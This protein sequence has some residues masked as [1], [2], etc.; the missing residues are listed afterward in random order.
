MVEV[1]LHADKTAIRIEYFGDEIERSPRSTQLRGTV[2]RELD[3]YAIYP[4]SHYVT[5]EE[6]RAKAIHS[7]RAELRER[8]EELQDAGKL[9]ERQRLEQR[10]SFDLEMLEQIGHCQGIENYSRHLS[11]RKA[12][13]PPPTLIDYLPEDFLM[14]L[15]ESHQTIP[16][17]GAMFRGDRARK[18]VL[19]AHGFRLPSALDN[20][21]LTFEEWETHVK[22]AI[23]VSATPGDYE[24][25]KTQGVVVEQVI[26][27]TGLMDP[28]VEVTRYQSV[29]D[30]SA[31]L[32]FA[33]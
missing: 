8:L 1:F 18:E 20:R 10:T 15:D 25:D 30:L 2:I 13:E 27:P 6:Q 5:P 29:T 24:I 17:V 21:P 23:Y 31:R 28:I 19:V 33:G 9:L 11:G 26:R 7:I 14:I 12:G 4:G 22:Q 32:T 3:R 16:Q